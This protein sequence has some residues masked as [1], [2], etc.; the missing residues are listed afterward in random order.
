M[1]PVIRGATLLILVSKVKL[2][3][4]EFVAVGGIC[5]FQDRFHYI[6]FTGCLG[7]SHG[8]KLV[9]PTRQC[10]RAMFFSAKRSLISCYILFR[11]FGFITRTKAG[12]S[13]TSTFACHVFECNVSAEEVLYSYFQNNS[14]IYRT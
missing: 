9:D 13:N 5:L 8:L 6:S 2:R 4:F 11:L 14:F 7:S 3:K 1:L 12:G 10:L